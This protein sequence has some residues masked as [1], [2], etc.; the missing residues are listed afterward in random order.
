VSD[1]LGVG[2]IGFA[3]GR[4]KYA[5]SHPQENFQLPECLLQPRSGRYLLKLTEPMEEAAY[6]DAARL[7]A[8]D[9]PPGR[10]MVLDERM[11]IN[12]PEP[13]GEPR[14]YR[15]EMLRSRALNQQRQEVTDTVTTADLQAAPVGDL[16]LR[17]IGR[18]AGE[19]SLILEFPR[20]LDAFAGDPMMVIDDWVEYPYSQTMFAAWQAGAD[21]RAPSLDIQGEDGQWRPLLEQFGYPAGMPRRMSLPLAGLPSGV[22]RLRLR[23][24]SL[25]QYEM[26][27]NE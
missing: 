5:Q 23:T 27:L 8:Y 16:D 2:G 11:S 20:S 15:N 3:I 22:T 14:F 10:Q 19:H 17:F 21:Y 18:L 13:T 7:T 9:L 25:V 26:S 24:N 4:G 12:G 6:L 1:I